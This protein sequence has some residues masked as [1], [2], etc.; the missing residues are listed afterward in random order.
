PD[1][2]YQQAR[3]SFDEKELVDLTLAIIAINGWNRLAVSFRVVPGTYQSA[4]Q[5][6]VKADPGVSVS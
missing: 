4:S 5:K 2:V 3:R 1:E 6:H